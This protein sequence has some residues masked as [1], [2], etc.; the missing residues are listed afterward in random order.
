MGVDP[1][2]FILSVSS[3]IVAFA[4]MI[5]PGVS[6]QFEGILLVLVRQPYD[7]GDRVAIADPQ[8][9]A[10]IDGSGHWLIQSI[11]LVT[12]TAKFTATGEV[13]TFSNGSLARCRLI[14]MNRS[15]EAVCHITVRFTA[16]VPYSTIMVFREAVENFVQ[17]RPQEWISMLGFRAGRVESQLNYVEYAIWLQHRCSW[18]EIVPIL[19]S[20]AALSSYCVEVQKEL[21]C[22]YQA[23]SM[24]VEITMAQGQGNPVDQLK[25]QESAAS[26]QELAKQFPAK[27]D[28]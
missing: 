27:K 25:S 22:R 18:Q 6:Q 15:P 16:D 24:G 9:V 8:D 14:N 23:P 2:V 4:F 21:G 19:V 26:L 20:K 17:D 13:A 11:D 28:D 5:G 10:S 3:F 1:F 12:T 7:I